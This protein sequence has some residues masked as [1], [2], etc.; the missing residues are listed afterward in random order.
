MTGTLIARMVKN[1]TIAQERPGAAIRY[2]C[3]A[4]SVDHHCVI[5]VLEA[6]K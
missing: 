1:S 4:L 3:F 2:A 6:S 5:H